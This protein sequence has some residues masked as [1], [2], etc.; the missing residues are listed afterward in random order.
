MCTSQNLHLVD[1]SVNQEKSW[2]SPTRCAV[3]LHPWEVDK[4]TDRQHTDDAFY[5]LNHRKKVMY[6]AFI[7]FMKAFDSV[8]CNI[9]LYKIIISLG[10][11]G[12]IYDNI[13]HV[14]DN[15]RIQIND[16]LQIFDCII[17]HIGVPQSDC[18][19][20]TS[21]LFYISNLRNVSQ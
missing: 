10:I 12:K 5:A 13:A 17:Q 7:E 6:A 3:W 18:L 8:D 1:Q 9:V 21:F 19:S 2:P 11:N 14:L 20:P 16:G 15:N 4:R